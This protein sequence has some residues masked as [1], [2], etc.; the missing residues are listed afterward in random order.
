MRNCVVSET[1]RSRCTLM[2]L[3]GTRMRPLPDSVPSFMMAFSISDGSCTSAVMGRT[4]NFVADSMNGRE[5]NL[6]PAGT[7]FGLYMMATRASSGTISF[8]IS[9]YF[10]AMLACR[11]VKPVM[12]PSGRAMLATNPLPIG[13]DTATNTIGMVRVARISASVTG[14]LWP[15][16][17]SGLSSTQLLR[18]RLHARGVAFGIAVLDTQVL[19]EGPALD[20]ETL[21]ERLDAS[22][23][24]GIVCEAHQHSDGAH[25]NRLLRIRR[26]RLGGQ[27]AA[28][29]PDELTSPHGEPTPRPRSQ[30]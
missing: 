21:F 28:E 20:F 19:A 7:E 12:L 17:H 4:F 10:P 1:I 23:G 26:D 2:K 15:R 29:Q 13:S 9:R 8:N 27:C 6:P 25:A 24:L 11:T 14:V 16:M 22:L 30:D 18:E 3:S 5:K